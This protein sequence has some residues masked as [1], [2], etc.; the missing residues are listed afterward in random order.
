MRTPRRQQP[1]G[2]VQDALPRKSSGLLPPKFSRCRGFSTRS[3]WQGSHTKQS[4]P[5]LPGPRT[6]ELIA[7]NAA[8]ETA[9]PTPI[10]PQG[11]WRTGFVASL[12]PGS[13]ARVA[14]KYYTS[15]EELLYAC[16]DVMREEYKAIRSSFPAW[17]RWTPSAKVRRATKRLW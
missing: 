13:C 15:D 4:G 17:S 3:A 14:N 8:K 2:S 7:A 16:A 1:D 5:D 9:T 10:L 12:S 11:S 6:P